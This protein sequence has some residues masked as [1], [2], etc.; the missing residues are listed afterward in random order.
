MAIKKQTPTTNRTIRCWMALMI[1]EFI[2]LE[3]RPSSSFTSRN[4]ANNQHLFKQEISQLTLPRD[5]CIVSLCS[6]KF[7]NT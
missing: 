7:T 1:I 6:F 4:Y 2:I 3:E 5:L